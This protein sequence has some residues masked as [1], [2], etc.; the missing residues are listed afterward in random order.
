MPPDDGLAAGSTGGASMAR[1][2]WSTGCVAPEPR[3]AAAASV[4]CFVL[5][6]MT[7]RLF[8]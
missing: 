5:R 8:A 1:F 7:F 6:M 2:P 3:C 4:C